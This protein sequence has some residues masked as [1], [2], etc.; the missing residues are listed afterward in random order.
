MISK[1][2]KNF[3][4]GQNFKK[5]DFDQ[6]FPKISILIK[7]KKKKMILVK[8]FKNFEKFRFHSNFR[9]IIESNLRK[10]FDFAQIFRK[11]LFQ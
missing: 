4:F 6:N 5:F 11:F 1:I 8:I 9:K 3:D 10:N 2:K 7:F